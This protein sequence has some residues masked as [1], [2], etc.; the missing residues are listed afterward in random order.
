MVYFKDKK[1]IVFDLD[2][3]L[4]N[5]TVDWDNLKKELTEKFTMVYGNNCN[6][7]SISRCLDYIVDMNDEEELRSFFNKI[8]EYELKNLKKSHAIEETIYFINNLE[9]FIVNPEVR[10]AILSL[11]M[12]KTIIEALKLLNLKNHID[13]VVGREDVRK[14]KPNPEGLIKIIDHFNIKKKELIYFGDQLKDIETGVNAG[15]EAYL[16]DKL[17]SV[18]NNKRKELN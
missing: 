3:T 7:E 4:I 8:E 13:Y 18:V 5:L 2:G 10:L 17:I 9:L 16:I 1:V 6:F 11:N 14:W 12:R 15:V